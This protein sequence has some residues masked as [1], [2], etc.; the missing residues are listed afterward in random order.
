MAQF[1]HMPEIDKSLRSF[2]LEYGDIDSMVEGRVFAFRPS[3]ELGKEPK[4]PFIYF[5]RAGGPYGCYRY[6]FSVRAKSMDD[7]VLLRRMLILRLLSPVNLTT[8]ENI[9]EAYLEGQLAD[10]GDESIGWYESSFYIVFEMLEAQY[11]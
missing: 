5:K 3:M 2:I 11:G 8:N 9:T 10:T 7:L 6:F 1:E 4:V